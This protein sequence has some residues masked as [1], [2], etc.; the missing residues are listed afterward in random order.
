[1]EKTPKSKPEISKEVTDAALFTKEQLTEDAG[2]LEKIEENLSETQEEVPEQT[3]KVIS[4]IGR[5]RDT[6]I[7]YALALSIFV[8]I[9]APVYR[10]SRSG[11]IPKETKTVELAKS[12]SRGEETVHKYDSV[13]YKK[14]LESVKK[15]LEKEGIKKMSDLIG[16]VYHDNETFALARSIKKH[17]YAEDF[18]NTE[19]IR[20]RKNADMLDEERW[21]D[22]LKRIDY[23]NL[24]KSE[25]SS[26]G[27][28]LVKRL[29][30]HRYK[31]FN[32]RIV[33]T[34][35]ILNRRAGNINKKYGS[36]CIRLSPG[37]LASVVLQEGM[38]RE[39]DYPGFQDNKYIDTMGSIGADSLGT[40][41]DNLIRRGLLETNFKEK[42]M[43]YDS[44][45]IV[46]NF[47]S[48]EVFGT[49]NTQPIEEGVGSNEAGMR[50]VAKMLK[51]KDMIEA[52]GAL[53]MEKIIFIIDDIGVERWLEFSEDEQRWVAYAAYQWGHTN[54]IKLL[55]NTFFFIIYSQN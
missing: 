44:F 18:I 11:D 49:E 38:A 22:L 1:M 47:F 42:M 39:I 34:S 37:F 35:Q 17:I 50:T 20:A 8:S 52:V 29:G 21:R 54:L 41:V 13:D 55:K 25:S 10:A 28:K 31:S 14:L 40:D 30:Y 33:T 9:G 5:S 24:L 36:E 51:T 6:L 7:R 19:E 2:K 3:I 27:I 4:L 45:G 53:L 23:S 16:G 43:P 26:F 46:K 32:D 12:K 48:K 15:R